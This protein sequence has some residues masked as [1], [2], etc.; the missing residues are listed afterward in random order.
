MIRWHLWSAGNVTNCFKFR[1]GKSAFFYS[2]MQRQARKLRLRRGKIA[3]AEQ[4]TGITHCLLLEI[5]TTHVTILVIWQQTRL[6]GPKWRRWLNCIGWRRVS[7]KWGNKR[8]WIV[9]GSQSFERQLAMVAALRA[10]IYDSLPADILTNSH[11][12]HTVTLAL[13]RCGR[14]L[15]WTWTWTCHTGLFAL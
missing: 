7:V 9:G 1:I 10:V 2:C 12:S 13:F 11:N 5:A 6:S 3:D 4:T 14:L 15:T 8:S